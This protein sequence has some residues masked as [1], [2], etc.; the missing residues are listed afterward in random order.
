MKRQTRVTAVTLGAKRKQ[1]SDSTGYVRPRF[2]LV[3]SRPLTKIF[4]ID[5]KKL[6]HFGHNN[7][8]DNRVNVVAAGFNA[9][10]VG[11]ILWLWDKHYDCGTNTMIVGQILWLWDKYYDCGTNTMIVGQM[12]EM[13]QRKKQRERAENIWRH[14]WCTTL[15]NVKNA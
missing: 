13:P 9:M 7:R 11:Q 6:S 1:P 2:F 10:I 3:I 4:V 14:G 15:C 5:R 12:A 8:K